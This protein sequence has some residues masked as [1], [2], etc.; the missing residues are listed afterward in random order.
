MSVFNINLD[1]AKP[2]CSVKWTAD[3]KMDVLLATPFA[4]VFLIASFAVS[5]RKVHHKD[6]ETHSQDIM[7]KCE[8]MSVGIFFVGTSFLLK[9]FLGGFDCTRDRANGKLY[10]DIDP[11]IECYTDDHTTIRLKAVLG[12]VM[13]CAIMGRICLTFLGENGKYKYSFLTTKLEDKWYWWELFLLARKTLIMACGLF[14]TSETSRGWCKFTSNLR[15]LV[16]SGSIIE[17]LLVATDCGSMV[18]IMA[19]AAH[20]YARPV[21]TQATCRLLAI[22]SRLLTDCLCLQ[23]KDELVDFCEFASLM[24]TLIIF[25]SGMVWNS[26]I[27]KSGVL[28]TFLESL[29]IFLVLGVAALGVVSQADALIHNAHDPA[30]FTKRFMQ[31]MSRR[32]LQKTCRRLDISVNFVRTDTY[33]DDGRRLAQISADVNELSDQLAGLGKQSMINRWFGFWVGEEAE[34]LLPRLRRLKR[35]DLVDFLFLESRKAD[36]SKSLGV[37]HELERQLMVAEILQSAPVAKLAVNAKTAYERALSLASHLATAKE[38]EEAIAVLEENQGEIVDIRQTLWR[39]VCCRIKRN[40]DGDNARKEVEWTDDNPLADFN[41]EQDP[42]DIGASG[43]REQLRSLSKHQLSAGEQRGIAQIDAL[44]EHITR[45]QKEMR[46]GTQTLHDV[47]AAADH[48]TWL[49]G[50][51]VSALV[52]ESVI[53]ATVGT[54]KS[55][56]LAITSLMFGPSSSVSIVENKSGPNALALFGGTTEHKGERKRVAHHWK[57]HMQS[58]PGRVRG[59]S[60]EPHD[61]CDRPEQLVVLMDGVREH[62][63]DIAANI[64]SI[65]SAVA[66]LHTQPWIQRTRDDE[67]VHAATASAAA[68]AQKLVEDDP[69]EDDEPGAYME[70]KWGCI[71]HNRLPR[72]LQTTPTIRCHRR[73]DMAIST[74]VHVLNNR[75][76]QNS[77]QESDAKHGAAGFAMR[78]ETSTRRLSEIEGALD[79]SNTANMNMSMSNM[80]GAEEGLDNMDIDIDMEAMSL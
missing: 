23:Y 21:R 18:I 42:D 40:S 9:G 60:F 1:L 29:S 20:A 76:I 49:F 27:D 45:L 3:T 55:G 70:V 71:H 58:T 15:L 61:F 51:V 75:F 74:L 39:R 63:I 38:F 67:D 52:S 33:D 57:A 11:G 43:E 17:R 32:S 44:H 56:N 78:I 25:Q 19:L 64:S 6:P 73:F 34:Q 5:K 36:D 22:C 47:T 48:S 12:L 10:L 4:V 14:N 59:S 31:P 28:S 35:D 66:H 41:E 80:A 50:E 30:H 65:E 8:A 72:P 53:E 62:T 2:E 26:A 37:Q 69:V 79:M 7:F 68:L 16:I 13:W 46:T 24:S 77:K 54:H